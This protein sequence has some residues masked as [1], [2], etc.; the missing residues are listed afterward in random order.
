LKSSKKIEKKM[1]RTKKQRQNSKTDVK[2]LPRRTTKG[3]KGYLATTSKKLSIISTTTPHD[4]ETNEIIVY[5]MHGQKC[6]VGHIVSHPTSSKRKRDAKDAGNEEQPGVAMA[7]D[8]Q[9][10][11]EEQAPWEREHGQDD[12][13]D[14]DEEE[15]GWDDGWDDDHIPPDPFGPRLNTW[16]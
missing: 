4:D 11:Q 16:F 13:D 15:G 2:M 7:E 1:A 5:D 12:D 14:D 6:G 9:Q 10:A 8:Q 3:F